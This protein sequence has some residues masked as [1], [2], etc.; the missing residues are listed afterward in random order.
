MVYVVENSY[1]QFGIQVIKC[2]EEPGGDSFI[3]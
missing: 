3:Q 2:R 1:S